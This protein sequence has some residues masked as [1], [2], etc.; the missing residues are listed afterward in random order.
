M[1]I[2]DSLRPECMP[3]I[4][5]SICKLAGSNSYK[6]DEIKRYITLDCDSV[7]EYNKAFAFAN[8]CGFI[9]SAGDESVSTVFTPEQLSSFKNFR[10][11]IFMNVFKGEPTMFNS[12]ARW[13]LSQNSDIFGVKSAQDLAVM[14]P[15]EIFSGKEKDSALGFRFW[16]VALGLCMFSK[17]GNSL[18]LVFATNNAIQEWL[19]YEKPFKKNTTILAKD[20]FAKLKADCPVFESCIDG[21]QINLALSMGLR[22]LHLNGVIELKYVT[23]S[24]DIWHL[25]ES[26]SNPR[27]NKITEIIVR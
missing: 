4:I 7:Q 18:C 6:K 12:L 19:E 2:A 16:M 14:F 20:F 27:T 9:K 17:T 25:V 21:N 23:D 26:I 15:K 1:K 8:E 22:V 5:Y 10:H 3:E 13:Y 24:G 11:A